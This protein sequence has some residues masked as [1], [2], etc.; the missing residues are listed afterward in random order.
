MNAIITSENINA[1]ELKAIVDSVREQL[2]G[3][4]ASD[5]PDFDNFSEW[6]DAGNY[7]EGL[8]SGQSATI[9]LSRAVYD[10]L[11]AEERTLGGNE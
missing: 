2:D 6:M 5:F 4:L 10:Q 8:D 7:Y 11:L 9:D 3:D 1:A